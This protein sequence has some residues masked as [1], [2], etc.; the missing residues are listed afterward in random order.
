MRIGQNPAKFVESVPQP[1]RVTV[2]IVTY[3]PFLSGYYAEM[4]DVLKAC[5]GS[6]WAHTPTPYDL[7]IF[8]NASCS[9]VREW[10][11]EQH[12]A[13]KIQYLVLS[14]KNVGKAAA[15]NFIF[16]AAPGEIIAYADA[17]IYYYPGWL[18]A[19][20]GVVD[21]FPNAGMVTG[22]P[23][24]SPA[25]YATAT[26]TWALNT[27]EVSL[28]RGKLLPWEDY[29]KHARSLGQ[30]K[31]EAKENFDK[32]EDIRIYLGDTR[33]QQLAPYYYIGAGH[34]QFVARKAVL[35]EVLPIPANRPMGQ[36]RRLDIALNERG[37]L[38]LST[39]DWWVQH[40][41]NSLADLPGARGPRKGVSSPAK[42]ALPGPVRRLIQWIYHKSFDL[43][44]RS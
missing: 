38:R 2:T 5:L 41:G 11:S 22:I 32:Q 16:A 40:L 27:R 26:V 15:W 19:L 44:Y 23:M 21:A 34:F 39:P 24:W 10:L 1:A 33:P 12:A 14:E 30:S 18:A 37:Y 31:A 4:L 25:Q 9:E 17:D 3:I 29:W 6:L 20:T 28:E 7:L 36:V 35:Q 43:L 42:R 8:D 13:G